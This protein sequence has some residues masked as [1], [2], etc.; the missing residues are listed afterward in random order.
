M[1]APQATIKQ[2]LARAKFASFGLKAP[3]NW[4]DP[5]GSAADHYGRAFKPEEKTS[6]PAIGTPPL[7]QPAS[8]NK[9][10][11]DTQKMM[12]SKFGAFI[13]GICSAICSAW[14]T[15]QSAVTMTG[16]VVAGPTV[17]VGQLVGPPLTPLILKDAP[18]G[19]PAEL[20]FSNVV[21]QVI[22][23]AWLS[24]TASIKIPGLPLFPAYSALP[25][26]VAPPMPHP[27]IPIAS[28]PQL[29]VPILCQTLKMQMIAQHADPQAQ[30][31]KELYEAIAHAFEQSYNQWKATSM[32]TNLLVVATGGTPVSPLPAVGTATMPPG[33]L[34]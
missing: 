6:T 24:F 15:W 3:Q 32:I 21:A 12:H 14:S 22:G 4:T 30:Y 7:F 28:L 29:P 26:P 10:H 33:G 20:K 5:Q 27:P 8:L 1:P 18:K 31:H 19:S 11:T 25:T 34:T 23:T 16:L 9:Y 2:Q 17:S 13:D